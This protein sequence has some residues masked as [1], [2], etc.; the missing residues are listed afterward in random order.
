MI[1]FL[2]RRTL[3]V[4]GMFTMSFVLWIIGGMGFHPTHEVTMATGS[5]LIALNFIYNASGPSATLRGLY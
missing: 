3:Y 5:L 4:G 2:G 1:S